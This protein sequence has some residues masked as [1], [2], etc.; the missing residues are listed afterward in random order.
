M[1]KICRNSDGNV[2]MENSL[3]CM[4]LG[5]KVKN[6][7]QHIDKSVQIGKIDNL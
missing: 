1:E 5:A 3:R 2:G 6:R 4:N 7:S